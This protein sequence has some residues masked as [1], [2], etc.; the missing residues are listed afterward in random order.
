MKFSLYSKAIALMV[1]GLLAIGAFAAGP[2]HKGN[3]QVADPFEV[4]GKHLPAGYYS[5]IWTGDGPD[6]TV[7]ITRGNKVLATA[8]AKVVVLDQKADQDASEVKNGSNGTRE[9]SAVRFS[10]KKYA[11]Q[12]SGEAGQGSKN[13][14]ATVK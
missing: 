1:A 13:S 2:A 9:L 4:N 6:V 14:G 10:G 8:P 3:F 5:V 11:L 12:I 7:N